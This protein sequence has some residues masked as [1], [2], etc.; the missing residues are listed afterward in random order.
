[1]GMSAFMP[2]QA[3]PSREQS[4]QV[5]DEAVD[6]GVNFFNTAEFYGI[7]GHNELLLGM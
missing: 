2:G 1:M 4:L 3:Q 7:D 5:I 6:A